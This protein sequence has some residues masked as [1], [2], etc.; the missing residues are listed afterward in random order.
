[1]VNVFVLLR[2][3]EAGDTEL[4]LTGAIEPLIVTF[5]E[6]LLPSGF[7]TV[8]GQVPVAEELLPAVNRNVM[9]F[10]VIVGV[11]T[12]VPAMLGIETVEP[13]WKPDPA[14]V[15]VTVD[16]VVTGDGVTLLT[17]IPD[18]RDGQGGVGEFAVR[19]RH[20]DRSVADG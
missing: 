4:T 11:P 6:S 19:I 20:L 18:R 10:A 9:E 14:T 13:F 1:M 2:A 16:P 7:V 8:T 5:A 12:I 3:L 15:I 17:S